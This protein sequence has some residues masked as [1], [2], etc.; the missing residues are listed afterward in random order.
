MNAETEYGTLQKILGPMMEHYQK[1]IDTDRFSAIVPF[2]AIYKIETVS[3]DLTNTN[4]KLAIVISCWICYSPRSDVKRLKTAE[5]AITTAETA[6]ADLSWTHKWSGGW[7]RWSAG[8]WSATSTTPHDW[9]SRNHTWHAQKFSTRAETD[10]KGSCHLLYKKAAEPRALKFWKHFLEGEV[11]CVLQSASA[12]SSRIP[13]RSGF[14]TGASISSSRPATGHHPVAECC[15]ATLAK[16][17]W[18]GLGW[19][20][21]RL[22]MRSSRTAWP[23]SASPRRGL[24]DFALGAAISNGHHRR[25]W[26]FFLPERVFFCRKDSQRRQGFKFRGEASGTRNA[27]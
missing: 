11:R 7:C 3:N 19:P 1:A 27:S 22:A 10:R 6:L 23:S 5:T 16:A 24:S 14:R 2:L 25:G 15:R 20:S 13:P 12:N 21:A 26:F 18:R 8:E 4:F 17:C 9:E